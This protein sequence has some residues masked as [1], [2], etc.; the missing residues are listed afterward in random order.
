[1]TFGGD[2]C[3]VED[4]VALSAVGEGMMRT[5]SQVGRNAFRDRAP[6]GCNAGTCR[7]S[8]AFNHFR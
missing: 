5:A 1:M 6:C 4:A 7:S 8:G 3:I 2:T